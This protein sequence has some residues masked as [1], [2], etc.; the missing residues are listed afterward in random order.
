MDDAITY[1]NPKIAIINDCVKTNTKKIKLPKIKLVINP[2]F[3][4]IVN[5]NFLKN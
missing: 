1:R 2:Y 5:S 3:A 4:E